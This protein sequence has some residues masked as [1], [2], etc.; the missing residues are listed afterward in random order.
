MRGGETER[1]GDNFSPSQVPNSP[2]E[3]LGD[4]CERVLIGRIFSPYA[5]SRKFG[6]V[7]LI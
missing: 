3:R 2:L 1:L 7:L 6:K 5:V 4:N